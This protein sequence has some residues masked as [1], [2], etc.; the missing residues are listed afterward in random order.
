[1]TLSDKI[2][3]HLG[4]LEIGNILVYPLAG[5]HGGGWKIE[6]IDTHKAIGQADSLQEALAL[7]ETYLEG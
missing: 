1:M 3:K 7:V 2:L 4:A 6:M 5:E